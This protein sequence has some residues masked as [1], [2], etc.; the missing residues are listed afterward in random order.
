M[1]DLSG[2]VG[3]PPFELDAEHKMVYRGCDPVEIHATPMRLLIYL[4]QNRNRIVPRSEL[5]AHVWSDSVVSETAVSSALNELRHALDDDGSSQKVIRTER[6][7]GYQFVGGGPTRPGQPQLKHAPEL[8]NLVSI[9]VLPFIDMSAHRDRGYV[10]DGLTEEITNEL[11]HLDGI[12][13]AART[14]C[15]VF[16]ETVLDVR[17]I[18]A[19]MNVE[20]VVEG[21]I[22]SQADRLRICAQLIRTSDGFH[23]W[24]DIFE[25]NASNII[26]VEIEIAESVASA[27]KVEIAGA[28]EK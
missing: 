14:S 24:S 8:S 26:G 17:D 23:L 7:R 10:A 18:G 5:L 3:F 22:R 28:Q 1:P 15:F 12:R 21:S 2:L 20:A 9:A 27:L 11:V 13:V 4:A 19:M 25:R 6:G 16:K